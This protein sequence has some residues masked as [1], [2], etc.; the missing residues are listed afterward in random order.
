[1][2]NTIK[3]TNELR[4]MVAQEG[5]KSVKAY[6]KF[7]DVAMDMTLEEL[8]AYRIEVLT[9]I[10]N[11]MPEANMLY[12]AIEGVYCI[13]KAKLEETVT[14]E[15][16][17]VVEAQGELAT[18]TILLSEEK[19]TTNN[20]GELKMETLV[21]APQT[22]EEVA[23][24]IVTVETKEE[25]IEM[26]VET[27]VNEEVAVEVTTEE[28]K[29]NTIVEVNNMT[30]KNRMTTE[31]LIKVTEMAEEAGVVLEDTSKFIKIASDY[32][33]DLDDV[34][35]RKALKLLN[36]LAPA[37]QTE[38]D[39]IAKNVKSDLYATM[40]NEGKVLAI[41]LSIRTKELVA[42]SD[43]QF[44]RTNPEFFATRA[45][46]M[47]IGNKV[48][49]CDNFI[50]NMFMVTYPAQFNEVYGYDYL[51]K[52][53]SVVA[54]MMDGKLVNIITNKLI[55]EREIAKFKKYLA[56]PGTAS[57]SRNFTVLYMACDKME[58]VE[59]VLDNGSM[60]IFSRAKGKTVNNAKA[61]KLNVRV[62]A[63]LTGSVVKERIKSF[64]IF[65]GKFGIKGHELDGMNF[66]TWALTKA[67][68]Q[69][70]PGA[71]KCFTF[72]LSQ[73]DMATLIK[74]GFGD[75][76]VF[77]KD[78]NM[79]DIDDA[80][81][82]KDS[83]LAG[84]V[85]IFGD[86]IS[87]VQLFSDLNGSK[88]AFDYLRGMTY[89]V[90]E[91]ARPMS[92]KASKQ[93]LNLITISKEGR[94]YI[95]RK[96]EAA[97]MNALTEKDAKEVL[98]YK[99]AA[100]S[101]AEMV[102]N[103]AT[104]GRKENQ[105]LNKAFIK[106]ALKEVQA[107]INH[108]SFEMEGSGRRI[109]GDLGT[110]FGKHILAENEAIAKGIYGKQT[111]IRYPKASTGS[112]L[113]LNFLN[114]KEV[115]DRIDA[116]FEDKQIREW[117]KRNMNKV[118]KGSMII[119]SY[120]GTFQTLGGAD[121]DFD[122]VFV[123]TDAEFNALVKE[124]M[125]K[126]TDIKTPAQVKGVEY[127]YNLLTMHKNVFDTIASDI[128]GVGV[129]TK[130][131]E[132]LTALLT[133][134]EDMTSLAYDAVIF[135]LAKSLAKAER[136]GRQL[137]PTLR[138]IASL[139]SK[140]GKMIKDAKKFGT[141][142]MAQYDNKLAYGPVYNF[143]D[144]AI[145][146]RGKGEYVQ[147]K[148]HG[149]IE[150]SEEIILA[151]IEEFV[152]AEKSTAN[153]VAFLQDC[154]SFGSFDVE[155]NIDGTK[156]GI[157]SFQK[158]ALNQGF[159]LYADIPYVLAYGNEGFEYQVGETE[160]AIKA[161]KVYLKD[162][163]AV[164][165]ERMIPVIQKYVTLAEEYCVENPERFAKE[166]VH[167]NMPQAQAA[168]TLRGIYSGVAKAPE[169]V[170]DKDTRKAFYDAIGNTL[171][172]STGLSGVELGRFANFV[173]QS[174]LG[175]GKIYKATTNAFNFKCLPQETAM[176]YL[177]DG[178][179]NGCIYGDKVLTTSVA[180]GTLNFVKGIACDTE[181]NV[182][183]M[184]PGAE[185]TRE[186][187]FIGG[188]FYAVADYNFERTPNSYIVEVRDNL[189]VNGEDY[190]VRDYDAKNAEYKKLM[191]PVT[192][193]P[194]LDL[195]DDFIAGIAEYAAEVEEV[196]DD[197]KNILFFAQQAAE[198]NYEFV[199]SAE[200]GSY[201]FSTFF[202]SK[203]V[204]FGHR[205]NGSMAH[206]FNGRKVR[207][208]NAIQVEGKVYV[209]VNF[210]GQEVEVATEVAAPTNVNEISTK[211]AVVVEWKRESLQ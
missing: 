169:A 107:L 48:I 89:N 95:E 50:E 109:Y 28:T 13:M 183:A 88:A 30:I 18:S 21:L 154:D 90:L 105:I 167:M 116:T 44:M 76:I 191:A 75:R 118:S 168:Y 38:I 114:R 46:K 207:I 16:V 134:D 58:L 71:D 129:I 175:N 79:A 137:S 35:V 5:P 9:A 87:D 190:K 43:N 54:R 42:L 37:N 36:L 34:R 4:N 162:G 127:E 147:M 156:T 130:S 198:D 77:A 181:G 128:D 173:A 92:L 20:K 60:G 144:Q 165:R 123:I 160:E 163:L 148:Q 10:K 142:N 15:S 161:H 6:N 80:Y 57:Q 8:K 56:V 155:I 138:A 3:T 193:M 2:E 178:S 153:L 126:I 117:L 166:Q 205:A 140:F 11:K 69:N 176:K 25:V 47:A 32:E 91:V 132:F 164:I 73:K 150:L 67:E 192:T 103:A 65:F 24:S 72:P 78:C 179:S 113:V 189:T 45:I 39:F 51:Y 195:T 17:L 180:S 122:C 187:K 174:K 185:G 184:A 133:V 96:L 186:I 139:S 143:F 151:K 203:E 211:E 14:D 66:A 188:A 70:R 136:M 62:M 152:R 159:S 120:K 64:A 98:T 101:F 204:K 146:N 59:T 110:L 200:K 104:D 149:V 196:Q 83:K 41:D 177:A 40:Y 27:K 1:M 100:G 209:V 61:A 158:V 119:N 68:V 29:Q 99:E 31:E 210:V 55:K 124:G 108:F 93:L 111:V 63:N 7:I 22:A 157:F 97:I 85:V 197:A 131:Y 194:E 171:A 112:Y 94:E 182:I 125:H 74:K 86:S 26:A 201:T 121:M 206:A 49:K 19:T 106:A 202:G 145:G 135:G 33:I 172:L 12:S 141:G 170:L 102:I 52:K 115:C 84:K 23:T 199:M 81:T 53:G 82:N 208:E